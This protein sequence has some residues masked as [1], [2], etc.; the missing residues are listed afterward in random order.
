LERAEV[1]YVVDFDVDG[2]GYAT[3]GEGF[4]PTPTAFHDW[5]TPYPTIPEWLELTWTPGDR[6]VLPDIMWHNQLRD[7]VCR[8]RARDVLAQFSGSDLH[9]VARG[10]L[11][12]EDVT[13]VQAVAVLD[14]VDVEASIPS[15]FSWGGLTWP[16]IGPDTESVVAR[17]VFRA[18][19]PGLALTVLLRDEVYQA[20]EEAGIP[21]L[22]LVRAEV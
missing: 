11:A 4:F 3:G 22:Q 2:Y 15:E 10:R 12:G 18:P 7:F 21:G 20:L 9:A 13:V 16:H 17:R 14:V 6:H 1:A 5:M 19:N 8:G